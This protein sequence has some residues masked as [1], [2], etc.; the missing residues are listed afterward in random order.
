ML[1]QQYSSTRGLVKPGATPV[2]CFK[3]AFLTV[4]EYL[5]RSYKSWGCC[6][7]CSST[8]RKASSYQ[9]F[10]GIW[11]K[12]PWRENSNLFRWTMKYGRILARNF[13][14]FF[15]CNTYL[16]IFFLFG[17]FTFR[18]FCSLVNFEMFFS[19]LPLCIKVRRLVFCMA[20]FGLKKSMTFFLVFL[21]PF[22]IVIV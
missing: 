18:L 15:F 1:G 17:L 6:D 9:P 14:Y 11:L 5:A 22:F 16:D 10:H 7:H 21:N 4:R 8:W 2:S 3:H 12:V 20:T 13:T 19:Q